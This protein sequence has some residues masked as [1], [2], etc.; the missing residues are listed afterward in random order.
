MRR[1][2]PNANQQLEEGV[3]SVSARHQEELRWVVHQRRK[4]L[5]HSTSRRVAKR[6]YHWKNEKYN[7]KKKEGW[8][9]KQANTAYMENVLTLNT[10]CEVTPLWNKELLTEGT[11][12]GLRSTSRRQQHKPS[13]LQLRGDGRSSLH[14]HSGL[15]GRL[16]TFAHPPLY[17][18]KQSEEISW[19]VTFEVWSQRTDVSIKAV[20][21]TTLWWSNE[22]QNFTENSKDFGWC[23]I[24]YVCGVSLLKVSCVKLD[25]L[26]VRF[27]IAAL[28]VLSV[29]FPLTFPNYHSKIDAMSFRNIFHQNRW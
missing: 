25:H 2:L 8:K 17:S 29:C 11:E 1:R 20:L 9:S 18:T 7:K 22:W 16:H 12:A 5:S 27:Q 21:N 23:R 13:E 6:K 28:S 15:C 14:R 24:L 4:T 26:V 19:R 3:S 10:V